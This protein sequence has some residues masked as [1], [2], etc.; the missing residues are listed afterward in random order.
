MTE[1]RIRL[2]IQY[3]RH[4]ADPRVRYARWMDHESDLTEL[5]HSVSLAG[6]IT[7]VVGG[8]E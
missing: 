2:A 6:A 1:A 7:S 5:L 4:V 8:Q 3:A